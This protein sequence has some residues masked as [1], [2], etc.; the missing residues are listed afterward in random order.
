MKYTSRDDKD[1]DL[2]KYKFMVIKYH[3]IRNK[4]VRT[5]SRWARYTYFR[6]FSY[7][8]LAKDIS[9]ECGYN[10]QVVR[11]VLE[12]LPKA[13]MWR[14]LMGYHVEITPKFLRI[15]P[16]LRLSVKDT[17]EV[18]ATNH[19]V[20]ALKGKGSVGAIVSRKYNNDFDFEAKWE[21]E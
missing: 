12:C 13:V 8:S 6:T 10:Q 1:K 21:K 7:Q 17:E 18:E 11:D 20:N 19:D 14:L 4:K 16:K 9:Y 15:Y 3:I 5:P 2:D